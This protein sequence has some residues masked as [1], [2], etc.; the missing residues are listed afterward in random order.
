MAKDNLGYLDDVFT[1]N[2]MSHVFATIQNLSHTDAGQVR[3]Y[4]VNVNKNI[5]ADER[6]KNLRLIGG[7]DKL[8]KRIRRYCEMDNKIWE[9]YS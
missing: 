5:L 9:L 6:L 7:D 3:D 2:N 8:L 4:Q 1:I